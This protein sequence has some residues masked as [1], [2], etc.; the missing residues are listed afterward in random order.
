M[1]TQATGA[2]KPHFS[3]P[4]G[5]TQSHFGYEASPDRDQ[6]QLLLFT[7]IA[8]LMRLPEATLRWLRHQG[9]VPFCFKSGHRV[10]AWKSDV[11]AHLEAERRAEQR[12]S[13]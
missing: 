3:E 13:A 6:D 10:V 12:T 1:R 5:A 2:T 11:I 8:E 7:E 4:A 9:R